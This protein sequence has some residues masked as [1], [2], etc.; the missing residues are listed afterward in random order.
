MRRIVV[1]PANGCAVVAYVLRQH[2]FVLIT[3]LLVILGGPTSPAVAQDDDN[4]LSQDKLAQLVAP[5][6]L[7]PDSLLSQVLMASTYPLEIVQAARWSDENKT[8]KGAALESAMQEQSWDASVKSLTVFPDVLKM[9]ND[10]LDWTQ[11][12]GDAFLA[13]QED[14]LAAV[15]TLRSRATEVGHLKSTKEQKVSKSGGG[16]STT[17]IVIEPASQS[18]VYVPVYNPTIVYGTWPYPAYPPYYYYPPGYVARR[19]FWFGVG[20]AAG[21]ALWG[22]CHWGRRQVNININRYNRFNRTNIRSGKWRHNPVHRKGVPYANREIARRHGRSPKNVRNREQFR[23]RAEAGRRDLK[24]PLTQKAARQAVKRQPPRKTDRQRPPAAR[25]KA[26]Q[27]TSPTVKRTRARR[28]P[29]KTARRTTAYSGV[30]SGK[31]ARQ[32]SSRGRA[33]RANFQRSRGGGGRRRRR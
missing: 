11:Q 10:K 5:I 14:V 16:G 18:L 21:S 1:F 30:A 24:R 15:Q 13:Q 20:I 4:K 12:L 6:A 32:H 26:R 27:R 25:K 8:V 29:T 28:S 33:S 17:Y 23:G 2:C 22:R 19:A 7:Y 9:M 31:R 3:L